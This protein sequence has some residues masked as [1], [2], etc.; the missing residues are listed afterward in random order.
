[1]VAISENEDKCIVIVN[2]VEIFG[3]IIKEEKCKS[4]GDHPVYYDKY[5]AKFCPQENKWLETSCSDLT[6]EHCKNRPKDPL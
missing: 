4:C 3:W 1:M 5:D 2:G 6:C